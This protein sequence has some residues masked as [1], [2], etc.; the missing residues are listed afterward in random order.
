MRFCPIVLV[1]SLLLAIVVIEF[2]QLVAMLR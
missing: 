1:G 2:L